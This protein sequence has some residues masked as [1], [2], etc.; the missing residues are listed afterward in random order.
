MADCFHDQVIA[1]L[2]KLKVQAVALTRNRAVADDLV[3]DAVCNALTARDSFIPGR[4]FPAWMH[5]ILRTRFI[6]NLRKRRETTD[7]ADVSEATFATNAAHEDT[8]ALKELGAAMDRL[9][10][11][12][13]EALV[14]ETIA[15][16]ADF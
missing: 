13:R 3:Q 5:R 12:Q 9:A 10:S 8:I 2:P 14:R 16:A 15:A 6:S 7:I 1:L 4:N 11:D